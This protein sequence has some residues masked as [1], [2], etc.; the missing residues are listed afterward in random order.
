LEGKAVSNALVQ[1]REWYSD[2]PRTTR[3][4]T[5]FGFSV[6]GAGVF[7]FGLWA[8]T[9]LIA[10]ATVTSG[11]FVATGQNKLI[12]HF[13]GGIIR[14]ILV[15]E[16]SIVQPGQTLILLDETAPTA[17]LRR[18]VLRQARLAAI[19]TRLR[20]EVREEDDLIF[21]PEVL[22]RA[23]DPEIASILGAQQLTFLARRKSLQSEIATLQEGINALEKRIEGGMTQ[24]KYV[25]EQLKLFDEEV[26]TKSQLLQGG[27]VK[28]SEV[29]ALRRAQAAAQ[30]EVGRLNGEIG[31]ARERIA[32]TREQ[33]S[34]VRNAAMKG[35]VEQLHEVTAEYNDV[36]ERVR[37]ARA[38]L[39]RVKITAPV[40]GV[41]VKLRYHTAGGVIEAGKPVMEILPLEEELIIEARIQPKD[42]DHVK[43][44]QDAVIR[45]TASNRRVT[46]MI[47]GKVIYVSADA[48]VDDRG[49]RTSVTDVY[50]ARIKLDPSEA[51]NLHGFTPTPGMP[52]EVYIQTAER[53]FFEYLMR[54]VMDTMMR[55]FRES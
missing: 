45:L 55:A 7:G 30:G 10:G 22:A 23:N 8:S 28:K 40:S 1:Q 13:E 46:P 32:R 5:L 49:G 6:L 14:E 9:A 15:R 20:T 47:T 3:H 29:L 53:T 16:G 44:G 31:D 2:V 34:A 12:Q 50:V 51:A 37:S 11:A 24:L 33:I 54:P 21:P 18:L 52:A 39:D 38:I 4:F 48:V 19:A 26:D 35:V 42:I 27:L 36:T 41:V 17:E 25:Y 43:Q